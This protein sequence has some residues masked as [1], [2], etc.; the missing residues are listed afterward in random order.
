MLFASQ[1]IFI[2]LKIQNLKQ[3]KFDSIVFLGKKKVLSVYSVHIYIY[4]ERV[5]VA[6][7]NLNL[8]KTLTDFF[9]IVHWKFGLPRCKHGLSISVSV[10]CQIFEVFL[11]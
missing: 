4:L 2:F 11:I 1:E 6:F 8:T 9:I 5:S 3:L 7:Q 10:M